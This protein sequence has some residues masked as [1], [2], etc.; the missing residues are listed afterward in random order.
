[1]AKFDLAF[2]S[3]SHNS[4]QMPLTNQDVRLF[5]IIKYLNSSR[6]VASR[7]LTLPMTTAN[8]HDTNNSEETE[9]TYKF[10]ELFLD[11][12][13]KKATGT[14]NVSVV[15]KT[16][17]GDEEVH[18]I[19]ILILN[20]GVADLDL[21]EED[22]I[23][24]NAIL[25]SGEFAE[26]EIKKIRKK[27][28]KK[29]SPCLGILL[30]SMDRVSSEDIL[31][32][33]QDLLIDNVCNILTEEIEEA[34]FIDHPEGELQEDFN[35]EL[36]KVFDILFAGED[37]F[38]EAMHRLD[39]WDLI[40]KHFYELENIYYATPSGMKYYNEPEVYENEITIIKQ[41]DG[42]LDMGEVISS[43]DMV[44]FEALNIIQ[45][46]IHQ[47]DI[48]PL[49]PIQL[50]QLGV[51]EQEKDHFEKARKIYTRAMEMGLDDFD[52]Q[53]KLAETFQSMRNIAEA[54]RQYEGF[55]DKCLNQNRVKDAIRAYRRITEI[56]PLSIKFQRKLIDQ[57][58]RENR[59][60]EALVQGLTAAESLASSGTARGGLEIL[61][62]LRD[63]GTQESQLSGKIVEF[64][65]R[66]G[67]KQIVEEE[68]AK[69][70]NRL[71]ELMDIDRA[72]EMYQ[73][74]FCE[75]NDSLKIRLKLVE[76]HLQRGHNKDVLEHING[77]LGTQYERMI[78]QDKI[79]VWLHK[80]RC[81]LDP[82]NLLS[83]RF[84]IKHYLDSNDRDTAI[85]TL[86]KLIEV[87][88][89]KDEVYYLEDLLRYRINLEKKNLEPQW[90]LVKFF[91][92]R[93]KYPEALKE[94]EKVTSFA[95][96]NKDTETVKK[97][98]SEVLRIAPFHREG[99]VKM[100]E[101]LASGEDKKA[102][103]HQLRA[104]LFTDIACNNLTGAREVF[105]KIEAL[106]PGNPDDSARFGIALL[107]AG[108]K[109]K[110][111][112]HLIPTAR[113][114]L[115]RKDL[116]TS[117]SI[118]EQALC[119]D[120]ENSEAQELKKEI[121]SL[122]E[123]LKAPPP[124][125]QQPMMPHPMPPQGMPQQ[126]Q[127]W[128]QY[129]VPPQQP[130][131]P[132]YQPAPQYQQPTA[133]PPAPATNQNDGAKEAF[134][135]RAPIK[136]KTVS[137][138]TSRLKNL[139][140]TRPSGQFSG[141]KIVQGGVKA[142]TDNLKSFQNQENQ[143]RAASSSSTPPAQADAPSPENDSTPTPAVNKSSPIAKRKGVIGVAARLKAL[144]RGGGKAEEPSPPA[145]NSEASE[146][147]ETEI[148]ADDIRLEESRSEE[149]IAVPSSGPSPLGGA[150]VNEQL[151]KL[152]NS[153]KSGNTS[154]KSK[155]L[156]G[157]ASK[158][159]Q[160]RKNKDKTT[161]EPAEET[162]TEVV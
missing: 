153:S 79:L 119:E 1:M 33:A 10:R 38:I 121:E 26:R 92:C 160:L 122:E 126:P 49:N 124:Q 100:S 31:E 78:K 85:S 72:L 8:K 83:N 20:G 19:S 58:I 81:K 37:V 18:D 107:T 118:I 145:E 51:E 56:D 123:R 140:N 101:L 146:T 110:G 96:E 142:I 54:K 103:V 136:K 158:L 131:Q 30:F 42:N 5:S 17:D 23:L 35:N 149:N 77:I 154:T 4:S 69:N 47:G 130:V 127:Q 50:Y 46:L 139:K 148:I 63:N 93:K 74:K 15:K 147:T 112:E 105:N 161:A 114:Y 52:I 150:L 137:A 66:C 113:Q 84:L 98:W 116:G 40:E 29:D 82:G 162:T 95:I 97:C 27:E 28:T 138:I 25:S 152:Q 43:V 68:L 3:P 157:P 133:A 61:L 134:Q 99:L 94:I 6:T 39:H 36:S 65:E 141:K 135:P 144:A 76:L 44:C 53:L 125:A 88:E 89:T 75:G 22:S 34:E 128:P 60:E 45:T 48:E 71:E 86:E 55:A 106:D 59:H 129:Q 111:V 109:Q 159:A 57:L 62:F 115:E 90:K 120:P 102:A 11:L 9:N 151:K 87:M 24:T 155:S 80:T 41:M 108:E 12:A 73:A 21:H 67:E 64:A 70:P 13:R 14:L 143:D 156:G 32:R 91:E 7:P 132:G 16:D 2:S 117:R 104:I